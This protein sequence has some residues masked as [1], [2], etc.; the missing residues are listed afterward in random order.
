MD[1]KERDFYFMNLAL[2]AAREAA[3]AEE[4]PIG[5]VLVLQDNVVACGS[6]RTLRDIDPTAHAEI[7]ALREGARKIGNHRLLDTTLYVTLEPCVMCAGAMVQ[8]RIARLVYGAQ[9]PKAG[10]VHTFF[11]VLSHPALNHHVDVT[12]G[13]LAEEAV[14]LLRS[15]FVARR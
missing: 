14:A 15:F 13:V 11:E 1:I 8:A 6:N 3:R 9:D 7:V 12:S 10:A 2:D 4:V 5:A